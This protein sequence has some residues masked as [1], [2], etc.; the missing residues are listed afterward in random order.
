MK[1]IIDKIID[2]IH[3][4]NEKIDKNDLY[5]FDKYDNVFFP[6]FHTDIEYNELCENS[7][8]N[9]WILLKEDSEV[10]PRGKM[11]IMETDCVEPGNILKFIKKGDKNIIHRKKSGGSFSD[12]LIKEYNDLSELKPKIRYLNAKPGEIFI[13]NPC[14][15]HCTDFLK[16]DRK[17]INIRVIYNKGGNK[18]KLCSNNIINIK[19]K[20]NNGADIFSEKDSLIE[21]DN[22]TNRLL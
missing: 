12:P 16:K 11:F 22:K 15:F 18:M 5:P 9:I 20:I 7:G 1:Y 2:H 14:V 4:D 17:S 3:Y 21:F 13:F 19:F 8:F 10:N 6:N